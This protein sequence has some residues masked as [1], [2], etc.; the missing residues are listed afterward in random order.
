MEGTMV[1]VINKGTDKRTFM[2]AN[3]NYVLEPN[4]EIP[5][6]FEAAALWFGDPRSSETIAAVRD[7]QTNSIQTWVPDRD[8]E[9]RR[10]LVRYGGEDNARLPD[11]IVIMTMEGKELYS[12][13]ADPEGEHV[14]PIQTSVSEAQAKDAKIASLEERLARME[15]MLTGDSGKVEKPL[16]GEQEPE[17]DE[18]PPITSDSGAADIPE[19]DES[20][21]NKPKG[22][23]SI[24]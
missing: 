19:A 8:S 20:P 2:Y 23:R 14:T 21:G 12:A 7:E 15:A 9:L 10:L 11:D 5:V 24:K 4:K 22:G 1:Y 18:V 17:P 6:P 3:R 16:T 13:A